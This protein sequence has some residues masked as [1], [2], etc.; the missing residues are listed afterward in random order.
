MGLWPKE[1]KWCSRKSSRLGVWSP[2]LVSPYPLG[3]LDHFPS[4]LQVIVF[5]G[6]TGVLRS[7]TSLLLY[8]LTRVFFNRVILREL[9]PSLRFLGHPALG[10]IIMY[11]KQNRSYEAKQISPPWK[12]TLVSPQSSW[13]WHQLQQENPHACQ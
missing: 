10:V 3:A 1:G 13:Y 9:A 4:S 6:E 8:R 2:D 12:F 7:V 11:N 5:L